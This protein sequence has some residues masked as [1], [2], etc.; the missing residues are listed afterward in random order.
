[1]IMQ[2]KIIK[3]LISII[4]AFI[5]G[6]VACLILA[7]IQ[8]R[9]E[10]SSGKYDINLMKNKIYQEIDY[11]IIT[12]SLCDQSRDDN[13]EL[14]RIF[15]NNSLE[16]Q[17]SLEEFGLLISEQCPNEVTQNLIG[18]VGGIHKFLDFT[19]HQ[20]QMYGMVY[21][22]PTI[23]EM[24]FASDDDLV[25]FDFSKHCPKSIEMAKQNEAQ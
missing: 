15:V 3:I 1:M 22:N 10:I 4:L 12:G 21:Y 18:H 11:L 20:R 24:L 25:K 16:S 13:N 17:A 5:V 6:V 7:K 9:M 23:H 2:K 8:K 19:Y 14:C